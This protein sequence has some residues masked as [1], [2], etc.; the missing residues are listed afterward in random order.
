M[1]AKIQKPTAKHQLEL[2][3]S[4][5]RLGDRSEQARVIKDTTRRSTESTDLGPWGS[6]PK[7]KSM[8]GWT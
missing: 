8:Q 1:E 6:K 2:G 7:P 5:G 4:C 3:E